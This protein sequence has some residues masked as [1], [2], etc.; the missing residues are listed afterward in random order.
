MSNDQFILPAT[1]VSPGDINRVLREL[2]GVN[3]FFIGAAARQAG[4]PVRPPRVTYLL[5]QLA[6]DN[7]YNLLEESNRLDMQAK[8]QRI[9]K[10]SPT[11]H[12]SFAAEPSPRVLDA[13]INWMRSNIHPY[14]LLQ[15]GLQPSIAAGCVLRTPN[16]IF[17]MSLSRYLDEQES[18]LRN[19]IHGATDAKR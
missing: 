15:V 12:I 8:L 7:K 2:D 17:N 4:T 16:R 18:Y 5:E 3:D 19:L 13:I 11:L 10:I 14:A 9:V 6:R 1:F